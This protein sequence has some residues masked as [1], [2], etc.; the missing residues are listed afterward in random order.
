MY[1]QFTSC[2]F[3]FLVKFKYTQQGDVFIAEFE[4]GMAYLKDIRLLGSFK[5]ITKE[6][7]VSCSLTVFP[8]VENQ[9][10]CWKQWFHTIYLKG[11]W[12]ERM[13][14]HSYFS[15]LQDICPHLPL[16]NYNSNHWMKIRTYAMEDPSSSI[17]SSASFNNKTIES[18]D[19]SEERWRH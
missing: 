16:G 8:S 2:V 1:V 14:L 18:Y 3:G 9:S 7:P 19:T 15:Q 11:N 6:T 17:L 12:S 10:D 4:D 13:F 5:E